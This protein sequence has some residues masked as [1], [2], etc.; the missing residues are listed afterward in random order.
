MPY[1]APPILVEVDVVA[2]DVQALL[3]LDVLDNESLV[4][5][6]VTNRLIKRVS[7]TRDDGSTGVHDE[8][9]IPVRRHKGHIYAAIDCPHELFFTKAHLLKMHRSF[10]HPSAQKLYNLLKRARPENATPET[11]ESLKELTRRCVPCQKIH[12][13]L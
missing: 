5:D 6:S 9:S 10:L 4:V 11:L 1:H 12:S 13:D 7:F 2:T 3:G 8:W